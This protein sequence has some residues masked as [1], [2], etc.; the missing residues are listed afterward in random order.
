MVRHQQQKRIT[1]VLPRL[2]HRQAV[3]FFPIPVNDG[4]DRNP[5]AVGQTGQELADALLVVSGDDIKVIRSGLPGRTNDTFDQGD[6]KNG[7]EGF[8]V[9]RPP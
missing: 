7:N 6:P 5:R 3:F 1:Q 8:A 2:E 9:P 4:G